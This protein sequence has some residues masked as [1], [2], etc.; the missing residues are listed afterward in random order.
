MLRQVKGKNIVEISG[1][2]LKNLIAGFEKIVVDLGTGDGKFAYN[3]AKKNP[4]CFV[5]GIDAVSELMEEISRKIDKKPA[6]GGLEN[7]IYICS[8]VESLP[9]E[10]SNIADEIHINFPWGSLLNGVIKGNPEILSNIK[11]IAKN[12]EST[13]K[14]YTTYSRKYEETMINENNLPDLSMEY[15]QNELT[16]VYKKYGLIIEEVNI[17]TSE[18]KKNLQ[19]SWVKKLLDK[20]Q[21]DV[22]SFSGI[23]K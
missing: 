4:N 21:R 2:E 22:Y 15:I 10:L 19:S 1:D 16:E 18:E 3:Y 7:I 14:C 20:R 9:D 11:K 8:A 23:I 6:K 12:S 17:L 13:F 5:I